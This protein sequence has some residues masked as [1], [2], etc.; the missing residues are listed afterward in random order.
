MSWDAKL[1]IFL[2]Q[3]EHVQTKLLYPLKY[4]WEYN[5]KLYICPYWHWLFKILFYN[6]QINLRFHFFLKEINLFFLKIYMLLA[7]MTFITFT[8]DLI[9]WQPASIHNKETAEL[10]FPPSFF[11]TKA[12]IEKKIWQSLEKKVIFDFYQS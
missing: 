8:S 4:S 3:N 12:N 2:A 7:L 6:V 11:T 9:G 5:K 10:P 1:D